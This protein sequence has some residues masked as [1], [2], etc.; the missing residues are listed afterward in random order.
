MPDALVGPVGDKAGD[1]LLQPRQPP[2]QP[3]HD[4]RRHGDRRKG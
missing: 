4:T 3:D 1:L 2:Q